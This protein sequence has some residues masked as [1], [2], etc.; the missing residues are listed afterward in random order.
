MKSIKILICIGLALFPLLVAGQ[1]SPC[2]LQERPDWVKDGYSRDLNNSYIRTYRATGYT[3]KEARNKAI[4]DIAS[5]RDLATGARINVQ[6]QNGTSVISG[7][8]DITVQAK[9]VDEYC[10]YCDNG[11]YRVFLLAQIA[12]F[13]DTKIDRFEKMK[14]TTD[15]AFSPRVFVPGMAQLQKGSKTKGMLFIAGEAALIGGIVVAENLRASYNSKIG[16]THSAADKK[17]YINSADNWQN[18]RN[19]LIAGAAALYVGNV[20]DGIA[21]KGKKHVIVLGD[22][23]V[24]IMPYAT[25]HSGGISFALNF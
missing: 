10:E 8:G 18:I 25:P 1:C 23:P 15:Y 13:P 21:A 19:G 20:I 5:D 11:Q 6:L 12:N 16:S 7:Q 24:Q 9:I 3:E 22:R 2:S 17:S 14:V 4:T